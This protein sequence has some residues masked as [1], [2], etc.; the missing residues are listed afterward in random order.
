MVKFVMCF[1][2]KFK[3]SGSLKKVSPG[4]MDTAQ[5][6]V[7]MAQL[8]LVFLV[9][10]FLGKIYKLRKRSFLGSYYAQ[11]TMMILKSFS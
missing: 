5:I 10:A 7:S 8:S 11:E 6:L 4:D 2:L 1:S 3:V 9:S